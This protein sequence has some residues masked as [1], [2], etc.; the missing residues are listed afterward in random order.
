MAYFGTDAQV[1]L[2][3]RTEDLQPWLDDTPGACNAAR[4]C[5][6][7][8][9]RVLGWDTIGAVLQRDGVFG[10]R[11]CDALE[12]PDI[13]EHLATFGYALHTWDVLMADAHEV[14]A[15]SR[16]WASQPWPSD[17]REHRLLRDDSD[18][19]VRELQAFM[20]GCGIAPFSARRLRGELGAAATP[21][22]TGP[23]G[24]IVAC[25]HAYRPHN[26]HSRQYAAAWVGLVSVATEQRG[27]QLGTRINARAITLAIDTL[28]AEAIYELVASD[29]EPSRRM[30]QACG[31]RLRAD[32]LCGVA[33][34]SG[35]RF[36]R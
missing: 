30:V 4:F 29:N 19:R 14:V 31:P 22:L 26:R 17:L 7:D 25:A 15:R 9:P 21:Y 20:A 33:S 12:R 27:R 36:T 16:A 10:F 11:L 35:Q 3:R 32:L 6:S 23:D 1:T 8:D 13:D 28:G 5:A 18:D 2:Q 34:S 24:R